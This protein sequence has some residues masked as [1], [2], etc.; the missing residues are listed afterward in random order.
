MLTTIVV[1]LLSDAFSQ[2]RIQFPIRGTVVLSLIQ[3]LHFC[4]SH[5]SHVLFHHSIF[6]VY[7]GLHLQVPSSTLPHSIGH[8]LFSITGGGEGIFL[9]QIGN[10]VTSSIHQVDHSFSTQHLIFSC[11]VNVGVLFHVMLIF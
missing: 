4:G 11:C 5:L 1:S 3:Q 8:F 9:G 10:H 2:N 7:H 6:S